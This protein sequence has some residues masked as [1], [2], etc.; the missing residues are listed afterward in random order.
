MS[1]QNTFT[2]IAAEGTERENRSVIARA[3]GVIARAR[4]RIRDSYS[5]FAFRI[6]IQGSYSGFVS[7]IRI[8]DSYPGF[9][10][11]VCI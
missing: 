3:S 7:R 11:R 10:F 1:T 4:V 5:G 2:G 9:V 6:R 8:Q